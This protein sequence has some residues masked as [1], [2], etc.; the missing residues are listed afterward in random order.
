MDAFPTHLKTLV[1]RAV[2]ATGSLDAIDRL[3]AVSEEWRD[4]V[5]NDPILGFNKE[6]FLQKLVKAETYVD[7]IQVVRENVLI[8]KAHSIKWAA[9]FFTRFCTDN[10]PAIYE[11]DAEYDAR[12]ALYAIRNMEGADMTAS[13]QAASTLYRG[14]VFRQV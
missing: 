3:M 8:V 4:V 10:L 1:A 6:M 7:V 13:S 5:L 9:I 2:D 11:L 12:G 14:S